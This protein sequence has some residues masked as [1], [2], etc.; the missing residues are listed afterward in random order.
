MKLETGS[1]KGTPAGVDMNDGNQSNP[2]DLMHRVLIAEDSPVIRR[3]IGIC[4]RGMDVM[5]V[6]EET[7]P[8]APRTRA[9][10]I[11]LTP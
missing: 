5:I 9:R 2:V 10:P 1:I 7:G 3:L 11:L 8:A 6:E 4:L